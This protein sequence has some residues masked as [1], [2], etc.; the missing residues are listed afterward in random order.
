MYVFHNFSK[1]NM[2]QM[3]VKARSGWVTPGDHPVGLILRDEPENPPKLNKWKGLFSGEPG[4][5]L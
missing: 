1:K 2:V 5:K 3:K 4:V